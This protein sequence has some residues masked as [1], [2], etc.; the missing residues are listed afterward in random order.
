[1][2]SGIVCENHHDIYDTSQEKMRKKPPPTPKLELPPT[3][4][5]IEKYSVDHWETVIIVV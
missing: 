5:Q 3:R 4:E 1:M 2:L